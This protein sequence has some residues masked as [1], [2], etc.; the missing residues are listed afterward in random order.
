MDMVD[1][2]KKNAFRCFAMGV[3]VLSGALS[4]RAEI[5]RE[6]E[7]SGHDGLTISAY[8]SA[9][10]QTKGDAKMPT[11]LLFHMAGAS[12]RGEYEETVPVLNAAGYHTLAVDLRSGGDRLGA[13]NKTAARLSDTTLGYCDVYPDLEAALDWVVQ[14]PSVGPVVAIGSS[15]SAGL[16]VQL[17]ANRGDTLAG[18]VAFS[19]ASGEPMAACRPE[20]YLTRV[21]VP[22]IAFRPD[23][24]MAIE[25]VQA[26]ARAFGE[27][28]VQYIEIEGGRHG[29]LMLRQS[30]TGRDMAHVWRPL[31]GFLDGAANVKGEPVEIGVD[32]WA[33]KGELIVP[34]RSERAPAVLLLHGAAK[35]KARYAGLA[36]ELAARGIASLRLD[37]RAHGESTNKGTFQQPW[38]DH[39]HLL[40]GTE[41][42]IVAALEVIAADQ[43]IDPGRIGTVSASYSGEFAAKASAVSTIGKAHV[44]L[45]PGSFSDESILAID[46]SGE[47]WFFVRAED[48]FDF[49]DDIFDFIDQNSAAETLTLPGDAHADALLQAHPS[50]VR[51]LGSWFASK[52]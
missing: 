12:A 7:F 20:N 27:Q 19:P 16:V 23:R 26:Q 22:L 48:E 43:R 1:G 42:D 24:E 8:W 28:G 17:A 51:I 44:S 5:G 35:T 36:R 40:D 34:K 50:L 18:A 30:Q 14:Q 21:E 4:A 13:P 46:P 49:F 45:A 25:S 37:L 3:L 47:P 33:L 10:A 9:A 31:L 29:S 32:G 6:V 39:R 2:I 38:A 52:L 11:V 41:R 15:F